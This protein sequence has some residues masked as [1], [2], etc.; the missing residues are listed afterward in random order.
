MSNTLD[1]IRDLIAKGRLREAGKA[2]ASSMLSSQ[3]KLLDEVSAW[4]AELTELEA[5]SRRDFITPMQYAKTRRGLALKLIDICRAHEMELNDSKN[6][7]GHLA[8]FMARNQA[9]V[10]LSYN[11]LDAKASLAIRSALEAEGIRVEMD[12]DTM[13]PGEPIKDFIHRAIRT[14]SATVCILSK[15]SLMSEWVAQETLLTLLMRD[16]WRDR[17]FIACFLDVSFLDLDF[18]LAATITIDE[19]IAEIDK[20]IPEYAAKHLNTSDLNARKSRLF[21]LRNGLGDILAHLRDSLCLDI[22]AEAREANL[23]RLVEYLGTQ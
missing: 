4:E 15:N 14:T 7:N 23:T 9:P 12:I 1:V 16:L 10:F 8:N 2:V 11:H 13:E 5:Q 22:R 18:H 17:R 6:F 3:S 19:R 20:L 21:S